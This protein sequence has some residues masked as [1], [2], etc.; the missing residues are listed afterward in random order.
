M[1]DYYEQHVFHNTHN[2]AVKLSFVGTLLVLV[3]Y[4]FMIISTF[5]E[6]VLGLKVC[7]IIGSCFISTGMFL[8]GSATQVR[9]TKGTMVARLLIYHRSG[10][11][12]SGLVYV[13]VVDAPF[14]PLYV[15]F[16]FK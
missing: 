12:I 14:L 16:T 11:C 4:S 7:L 3:T 8:A 15:G 6:S 5:L 1:Q 13:A 9:S 2:V 10:I